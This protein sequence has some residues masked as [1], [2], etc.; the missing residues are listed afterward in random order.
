[1]TQENGIGTTAGKDAVIGTV[2]ETSQEIATET[3]T[4]IEAQTGAVIEVATE[5][6]IGTRAAVTGPAASDFQLT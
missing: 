5:T 2:T 3:A 6:T 4:A 1:M